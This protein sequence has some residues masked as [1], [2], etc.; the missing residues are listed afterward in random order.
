MI[1]RLIKE[2]VFEI[3]DCELLPICEFCLLDKMIKSPFKEKSKWA[4]EVLGLIDNDVCGS[5]NIDA[6]GG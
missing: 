2:G 5:M 3:N 6:R 4:S 1:G